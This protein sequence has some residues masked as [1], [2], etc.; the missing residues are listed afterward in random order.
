[1]TEFA[2]MKTS[3]SKWQ[4]Y[5]EQLFWIVQWVPMDTPAGKPVGRE[6]AVWITVPSPIVV[7]SKILENFYFC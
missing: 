4:E 2:P 5:N 1:M 7:H 3:F 6:F